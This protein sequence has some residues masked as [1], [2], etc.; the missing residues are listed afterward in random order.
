[1]SR[2]LSVAVLVAALSFALAAL[3]AA[4]GIGP[5]AAAPPAALPVQ[6]APWAMALWLPVHAWLIASAGFGHLHRRD[7]PDWQPA[8]EP[9]ALSLALGTLWAPVAL[10]APLLAAAMALAMLG[11]A[12]AALLRA[13]RGDR[14]WQVL[15]LGL[16]TGWM[17][18][19]AALA[20][21][22]AAVAAT[23]VPA[24]GASLMALAG[25]IGLALW[26]QGRRPRAWTYPAAVIWSLAGVIGA[27]LAPLNGSVVLLAAMGTA[28]LG[29][30][31]MLGQT[32]EP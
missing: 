10:R 6:P 5:G 28:L 8:R 12:A 14:G 11:L 15:P 27:N 24:Q 19:M 3:V 31:A 23:Q 16:Y 2:H 26:V 7:A 17:T 25:A 29:A 9:L 32:Q 21:A 22:R 30:R 1:M 13:G 18:V 20:V 4:A